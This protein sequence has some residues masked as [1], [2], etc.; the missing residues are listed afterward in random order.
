MV[1]HTVQLLDDILTVRTCTVGITENYGIKTYSNPV[2]GQECPRG[3]QE[4]EAP[5]FHDNGTGW[6]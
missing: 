3:F 6:W 2:T 4:V 5:R 1:Y